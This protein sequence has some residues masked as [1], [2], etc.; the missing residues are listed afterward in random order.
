MVAIV[1]IFL[2]SLLKSMQLVG[3]GRV[4]IC[5]VEDAKR[6]RVIEKFKCILHKLSDFITFAQIGDGL[7]ISSLTDF[8]GYFNYVTSLGVQRSFPAYKNIYSSRCTSLAEIIAVA[9]LKQLYFRS[10]EI[11]NKDS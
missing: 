7:C 10:Q 3:G 2:M 8:K 11:Q 6:V 1:K 4:P 5:A 9:Y